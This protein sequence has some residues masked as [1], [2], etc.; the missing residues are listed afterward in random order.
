M[1]GELILLA[2]IAGMIGV[3]LGW[4][5]AAALL[6]DVA[7]TLQGLYGADV[8]GQLTL[9]PDWWLSGLAMAVGGALLAGVGALWRLSRLPLMDAA[10]GGASGTLA[11]RLA[12]WQGVAAMAL[13]ALAG[14]LA[15]WGNG[16]TAGF[17]LLGSLLLGGALALPPVLSAL[18]TLG[19]QRARGALPQWFWA[20]ARSG[21]SGLSLALMALMLAMAANI[22]VATMVSSFRLTFTAFLDQRLASELYLQAR[23]TDEAARLS[24][25]VTPRV[26]AVLPLISVDT[27]ITGV[28]AALYAARDHATYRDNWRFLSAVP[29]PWDRLA[30]QDGVLINEQLSRRAGL[31]VG[32]PVTVTTDVTLP[33]LGIYGDYGN[34]TGQVILTEDL[35]RTLFP[36]VQPTRFGLRL[37]ADQAPALRAA[38]T[39]E[40]GLPDAQIIDQRAIKDFSL[41]VFDRTFTVTA[42]LNIL[43]LAVA[44]FALLTSLLTLSTMRLPQMAPLWAL[45]LTRKAL[46]R[47]DLA[48]VLLLAAL[49]TVLALPLGL[50]L[51]WVLLNVVNPQA[52]GWRLP[53]YLF[54]LDY[55]R[56]IALALLAAL[57]AALWPS[58]RLARSAPADLLRAF[59]DER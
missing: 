14:V 50:A 12:R 6:P 49:T 59:A 5:I 19:A 32:D 22:G 3:A 9:R 29:D 34:P 25:W 54:P 11:T 48:R 23:D 15:L 58:L 18:L 33:V 2:L 36:E 24:A 20:D 21:L 37:P 55:A 41:Q 44:A 16:L 56:L 35:M 52:F 39:N 28:A 57:A 31:A 4:M 27:T 8:A 1:L 47:L 17:V 51:A 10:K 42:A 38:L 45:G 46:G 43:T 53:M 40:F 26:D 30:A 13:F 7:A